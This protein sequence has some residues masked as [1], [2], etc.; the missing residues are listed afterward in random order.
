A[1][2]VENIVRANGATPATIALLDGTAHIGLTDEQ[3]EAIANRD[4]AQL[5][6]TAGIPSQDE[7]VRQEIKDLGLGNR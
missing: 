2:E 3:L 7:E 6:A 4:Y 5:Q 1:R